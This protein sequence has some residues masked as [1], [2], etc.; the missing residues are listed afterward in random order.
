MA[1]VSGQ[2]P[3]LWGGANVWVSNQPAG[4]YT[5]VGKVGPARMGVTTADFGV[6]PINANGQTIDQTNTLQVDLTESQG[7]LGSGTALDATTLADP[8]YVGGEIVTY[9]T[10]TLLSQYKYALNYLVRG[11]FGTESDIVDHPAGTQFAR[12]DSAI[13]SFPFNT[14]QIGQTI[15]IKFQGFNIF[16]GGQQSLADVPA[17]PYIIQGAALASPLPNVQNVRVYYDVNLGF[18]VLNWDQVSDFRTVD[19]EIRNG[20]TWA[21]AA[22]LGRTPAPPFRVPGNGT[23]WIAAHAQPVAGLNVYSETPTDVVVTGA[24][25]TQNIVDTFDFKALGWPGTFAGGAGIDSTI[26][27]IRTGAGN[28]LTGT[29]ILSTSDILAFGGAESGTYFPGT[30]GRINAGYVA[31]ISVSIAYEPTGLP[32]GQNILAISNIL[33]LSDFL[34]SASTAFTDVYPQI[35][36]ATTETAGNPNF[37]AWQ[38]FSPGTYQAQWIETNMQLNTS[39]PNTYAYDLAYVL[40][41]TIPARI[42]NYALTTQTGNVITV[43]FSP[44]GAQSLAT[45]NSTATSSAVLHVASVPSWVTVG[46]YAFDATNPASIVSG[47]TVHALGTGT[48]T[49][50][51]D[52][53]AT[54]SSGDEILFSNGAGG[55]QCRA[56]C[57]ASAGRSRHHCC[58]TGG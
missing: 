23:F 57:F 52:V 48:I 3:A 21:S 46:T 37:G 36:I 27:A 4:T 28:I 34:G 19:Y 1:A 11:A 50:T 26:N 31:N 33:T 44:G 58:C 12:L 7:S 51:A 2:N 38:S 39:D 54:V 5:N 53:D 25:I 35:R 15:Y 45:N 9:A 16:E 49:L 55:V 30:S 17:F 22:S 20:S 14:S 47:Q 13:G 42:D 40:T 56:E 8:C 43:E 10:A 6:V 41:A 18:T 32:I 29:N 24:V